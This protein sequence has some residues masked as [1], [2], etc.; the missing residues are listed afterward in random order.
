MLNI[1]IELMGMIRSKVPLAM[2]ILLV[3]ILVVG[4]MPSTSFHNGNHNKITYLQ[5]TSGKTLVI[6]NFDVSVDPGAA[7]MFNS[8]LSGLNNNTA[9]VVIEMNTQ[10]GLLNSMQT[11]LNDI[12]HTESLGIPVFTYVTTNGFAAY[13][14]AYIAM[15]S[16]QVW[17]ARGSVIGP[18]TTSLDSSDF[19]AL[20]IS[21]AQEHNHNATAASLMVTNGATYSYSSA[22]GNGLVNGNTTSFSNFLAKINMAG[23]H[24][25]NVSESIFDQFISFISNAT[26]DGLLISFGSLAIL[27]D[28]YHR[29]IFM[30]LLGLGLIILGFLGAQLIDAS[31]VGL[32]FL[33]MG[34]VLIFLEFK[35][36]H[37]IALMAG[38]VVDIIG[39]LF[40]ISPQYDLTVQPYS[41]GYSPSPI[42]DSFIVVA[43]LVLI[44]AAFIAYYINRIVRSQ[45][46]K[47][48]TGWES[49]I[50]TDGTADTD[51]NPEGWISLDGVRWKAKSESNERIEKGE[52]VIVVGI[53]NLTLIVKKV[54]N[55]GRTGI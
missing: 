35:T 52:N 36:G 37:G 42:N 7:D 50:G 53:N 15:A 3:S 28:L 33:V 29:T 13:A 23:F 19:Q 6:I 47:P 39:T 14:G 41:S 10:G 45:V 16:T 46:R 51:I 2:A 21:I 24:Q 9:G 20:M 31:V 48:V 30:T 5:N 55:S 44:I 22:T 25:N 32:V 49:M 12:N 40:L 1:S 38:V 27:L 18:A 54:E 26:V 4:L 8:A 17:M 34:S 43:I 11:I